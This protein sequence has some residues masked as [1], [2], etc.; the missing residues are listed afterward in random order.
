ML[1]VN[2]DGR[3]SAADFSKFFGSVDDLYSLLA[4]IDIEKL[5]SYEAG[6]FFYEWSG[7]FLPQSKRSDR[8]W[9]R[10]AQLLTSLDSTPLITPS[11]REERALL[12]AYEGEQLSVRRC[13]FAS[14]GS[15]D[16]AGIGAALGHLKDIIIGL[17]EAG[18]R[19]REISARAALL[20]HQLL[21]E[22]IETLRS[23]GYSKKQIRQIVA[24]SNPAFE[25]VDK[26]VGERKIVGAAVVEGEK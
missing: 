2:I 17:I 23:V 24:A 3:W 18:P 10:Y 22:R 15:I 9:L 7:R 21:N 16:L 11:N 13:H 20:E 19:R 5:E 1:R 4:L 25:Q 8:R 26:L 14:P 6:E 12:L